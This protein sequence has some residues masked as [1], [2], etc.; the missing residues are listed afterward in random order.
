MKVNSPT[1]GDLKI[2]LSHVAPTPASFKCSSLE[3][4]PENVFTEGLRKHYRQFTFEISNP[5]AIR[6]LIRARINLVELET[7]KSE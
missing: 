3:V 4:M 6:V 7:E 5:V 1:I 2:G